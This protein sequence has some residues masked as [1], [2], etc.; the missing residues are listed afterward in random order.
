MTDFST[1]EKNL[2]ARG[3]AVQAF[4]TGAEAA[5]YLDGAIDG[6][7]VGFG[8]S[9]TLNA[10]GLY[11]LLE[12]HNTV[13]WHWKQEAGPARRAAMQTDIYLSSANALAE[14]GEIVNIDGVG[15]RAAATMF[16]HEKVY[17]VIGR[18]K[19]AATYDEAVWRARNVAAPR[20][21]RQLNKRTPC[22][23][24][25]DRCY[26]CKSPDRVCR[27]LVTLW[28]PMEGMKTEVVLVDEDLGL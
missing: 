13:I 18:N 26:D 20:R 28:A 27:A 22:A 21:A 8:G 5:A 4:A 12:K 1:V 25:L 16:G 17:F 6:K 11:E 15:N 3:F 2:R 9:A 7:T 10:L 23:V 24:K 19:L 14:T